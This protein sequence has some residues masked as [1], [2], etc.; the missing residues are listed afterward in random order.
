MYND[1]SAATETGWKQPNTH[2]ANT[3]AD[4]ALK[5]DEADRQASATQTHVCETNPRR[6]NSSVSYVW[7]PV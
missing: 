4:N 2:S 6:Q 7:D 1:W 3:K 5:E